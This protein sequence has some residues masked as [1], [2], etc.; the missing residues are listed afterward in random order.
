VEAAHG[1]ERETSELARWDQRYP[2]VPDVPGGL[3]ELVVAGVRAAVVAPEEELARWFSWSLPA[4]LVAAL[5][6][7]GRLARPQDGWV[8]VGTAG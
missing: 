6:E 4:G 2:N 8:I 7:G 1:G 3:A 5:V